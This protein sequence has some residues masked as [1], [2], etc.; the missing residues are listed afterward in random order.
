M[1]RRRSAIWSEPADSLAM[2]PILELLQFINR[3]F[4]F[5]RLGGALFQRVSNRARC[6]IC[7]Q[8]ALAASDRLLHPVLK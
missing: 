1:R 8:L 5:G 7:E 3:L 4:Q 2:Q 6:E